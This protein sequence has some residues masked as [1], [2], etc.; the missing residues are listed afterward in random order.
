MHRFQ[1]KHLAVVC[2]YKEYIIVWERVDTNENSNSMDWLKPE[3][4]FIHLISQHLEFSNF[5]QKKS[6]KLIAVGQNIFLNTF[7][8]IGI[9]L[10]LYIASVTLLFCVSEAERDKGPGNISFMLYES[11]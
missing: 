6:E 2:E 9:S 4:L 10:N 8:Y 11:S 3:F 5:V 7:K 1:L